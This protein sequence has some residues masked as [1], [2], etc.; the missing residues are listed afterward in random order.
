[1][2]EINVK[3]D[4]QIVILMSRPYKRALMRLAR[5]IGTDMS[6]LVRQAVAEY[7]SNHHDS[8]FNQIYDEAIQDHTKEIMK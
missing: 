3:K 1:M 2:Y 6:H 5:R 8:I 4:D 7:I